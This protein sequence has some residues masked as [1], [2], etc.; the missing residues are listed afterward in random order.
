[1]VHSKILADP[2]ESGKK[3][4]ALTKLIPRPVSSMKS[5]VTVGERIL[6]P[7]EQ[8]CLL[9]KAYPSTAV[10][11]SRT[12]DQYF[13]EDL[14][15][16]EDRDWSQVILRASQSP[17]FRG[18]PCFRRSWLPSPSESCESEKSH[19]GEILMVDQLWIWIL[20]GGKAAQTLSQ[21]IFTNNHFL[22]DGDQQFPW[23]VAPPRL[24]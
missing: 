10:H 6:I 8:L 22:R 18:D 3:H 24:P 19:D 5:Y 12:L 13:Y 20:N 21:A 1:M 17:E 14:D 16:T 23:R 15:D 7:E 9:L 11:H 2:L 4:S